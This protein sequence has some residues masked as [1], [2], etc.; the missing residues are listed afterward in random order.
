MSSLGGML[1]LNGGAGGTGFAGP[2]GTDPGQL[3]TAYNNTQSG[4]TSQQNFLNALA[5]QNGI[6]NQMDVYKQLQGISQGTGPNPAQAML[7]QATG[8]NVANQA[9]LMAGQRGAGSNPALIA[10]QAAQQGANI[11]QQAAGQGATMQAQQALNAVNSMGQ[12]ANTQVGQQQTGI[13]GLNQ[14]ADTQQANLLG[15]QSNI[16]N[17]NAGMAGTRMGQQGSLVGGLMNGIGSMFADGGSVGAA[18]STG[19]KSSFGKFLNGMGDGM[20]PDAA[21]APPGNDALQKGMANMVGSIGRAAMAPSPV[22]PSI[23]N[24]P[25]QSPSQRIMPEVMA[26]GGKVPAMVSPGENYL[27]PQDVEKVKQGANPMEVGKK[28]PGKPKVG[29]AKNSYKND[30][31]KAD[32]DEGG[33]VIPRSITQG[34]NPHWESMK[35]V[36]ATLAK[37]GKGPGKK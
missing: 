26:E 1:G 7:N 30:T 8:Q 23:T 13:T 21:K 31:V 20:A 5:A 29:G 3:Q 35:F 11:Q 34:K 19:P 2:T 15:I 25:V 28:V 14:A 18:K 32:L 10:R 22:Q 9:S 4:I 24:I 33:I 16:N 6:Q 37:N 36:R 12:M 17:A 27:D